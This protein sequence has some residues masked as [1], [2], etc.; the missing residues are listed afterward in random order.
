[1]NIVK[2]FT[3]LDTK[4][5]AYCQPFFSRTNETALRDFGVA[6]SQ[7]GHVFNKHA[8]DYILHEIGS[9]DEET[10]M[11]HGYPPVALATAAQFSDGKHVHPTFPEDHNG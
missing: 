11:I 9:W 5:G 8:S 2:I 7:E 10:G 1:M 3:V 6:A 4:A